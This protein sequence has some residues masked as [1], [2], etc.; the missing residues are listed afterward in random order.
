MQRVATFLLAVLA[1]LPG[2]AATAPDC[3]VEDETFVSR[4]L[5]CT[6]PAADA[7]RRFAF[8]ANFSGGHDDTRASIAATLDDQPLACL[9]G[10]KTSLFG[11]DGD[12]SL[13]C[14][15]ALPRTGVG[16]ARLKV[17]V[18]WSH[19]EYTDFRLSRD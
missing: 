8:V 6:L 2:A 18:R 5:L 13:T 14:R 1:Q 4:D 3:V 19:A 9:D 16:A 10:S 12:V 11:E 15:F 7:G 17:L